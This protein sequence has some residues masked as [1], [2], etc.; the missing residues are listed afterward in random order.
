MRLK[1]FERGRKSP[2]FN[3]RVVS[4]E[5]VKTLIEQYLSGTELFLVDIH[6]PPGKLAVFI[7]K[8]SGVLLEECSSL[9][10]FLMKELEATG[11]LE[12]HDIE[13]SSPGIDLP[14]RVPGQ[15]KRR[16]GRE[17]RVINMEGKEIKGVLQSADDS[18]F[19][20]LSV[21]EKKENKVKHRTETINKFN[22]DEV[23]ET[24]LILN[25]KIK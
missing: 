23:R 11:F 24:K 7:D 25:F 17:L 16:V 19:E 5:E 4:K 9:N 15:F 22:Y 8:P 12:T 13:V 6:L 18:G 3:Y 2:L 10:R 1:N 20:L 14:L 21:T